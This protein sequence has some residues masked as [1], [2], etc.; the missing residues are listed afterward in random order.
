L[1]ASRTTTIVVTCV[2]LFY[3]SDKLLDAANSVGAPNHYV[4]ADHTRAADRVICKI[5]MHC[6]FL[7]PALVIYFVLI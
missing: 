4:L 7:L 5:K 6:L 3:H 2:L 1:I